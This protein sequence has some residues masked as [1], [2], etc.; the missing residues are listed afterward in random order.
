MKLPLTL[1]ALLLTSL[2]AVRA[3]E[4]LTV[5]PPT[6]DGVAPTALLEA[7]LKK[8]AFAALDRRDA[9]YEKIKTPEDVAAWQKRER[10]AFLT[11][12]GGLPERTPLNARV[13]GQRDCGEYR[14]EKVLFESQPGF[15]V[16]GLLY[17]PKGGGPH[18]AVLMPCGHTTIAKAGELYQRASISLARAGLAVFCYD[19]IGQGERRQYRK[20]DG[21]AEFA[22]STLEHQLMGIA[23][24]PLGT[25]LARVMIWDGMRALDYLQSRPE[26]RKDKLGCTGVSGGGT[27][28]SYLVALDD[29][30][31]AAAPACYLTGFRRLLETIG[32]QDFE[33]NQFGQIAAGLDHA[34]YVIQAAP[35]PVLIMAATRDFFDI[36][37]AWNVFRQAKRCYGRLGL[38]EHVG[39]IE[40][41]TKHDLAIDMREASARWFRRWLLG[42]DDAWKEPADLH[43]LPEAEVL[44][45][46][47]GD[48]LRQ[49]GARSFF[50]LNAATAASLVA[51]R[52]RF[53]K[54]SPPAAR[55]AKVRELAGIRPLAEIPALTATKGETM[56]RGKVRIEKLILRNAEGTVLPA[57]VFRPAEVAADRKLVLYVSGAGKE[58]D[59]GAGGRLEKAA[60]DGSTV[61]AV[62]I[63]GLGEMREKK[64]DAGF[65]ALG[66]P[67]WKEASI[68]SLLG[69]PL[70]GLRAEDILACARFGSEQFKA[71]SRILL[72]AS[73]EAGVPAL[74]AA[75]LEPKLIDARI[76][77]TLLSWDNVARSHYSKNQQVNTVH[78]ALHFY[79]LPN[80]AAASGAVIIEPVD[81]VGAVVQKTVSL[82]PL[83]PAQPE[84]FAHAR[85]TEAWAAYA[86]LLT[87]G[88]GQTLALLDDGCTM[89]RPEWQAV[90]DGVPKVRVTFDAVDGD[91]DPKHEGKG[92][93]GSTIGIPS[94]VNYAGKR[95]VAYNDQV[96]VVRSL[97]CCHCKLAD[98]A[99][100]ARALQWVIDHHAEHRITTVNLSPVDDLAHAEPVPTEIDPK[101]AELRGL[102]IWV[103]A[104]AGNHNFTKGISWPASQPNCFAIGAVK[105]G[106]DVVHLDRHEKVEL[107][108]PASATSSS[109]A[110]ICGAAMILREAIEKNGYDWKTDGP[111]IAEAMMAIFKN[112]GATVNDPGPQRS[113]RRLDLMAALEHV[114]KK[115]ANK[116]QN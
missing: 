69:R 8:L 104:P 68:A 12:I 26:I 90:I 31:A 56:E 61:L 43:P 44:C 51:E 97:E 81:A 107:L 39:L 87:F 28:T 17:L 70:V 113:Y 21:T 74:H 112:T 103:S 105:P 40:A 42:R 82:S 10:A 48:V 102:G 20:P 57:L 24:T 109:N 95:G 96:A 7:Q 55:L 59:A 15:L 16:S 13:T 77:R 91:N 47:E 75:A 58:A 110:I 23:G 25:G 71:G 93:H 63:R 14:M 65:N 6:I 3:A 36:Q 100:L 76:E 9:E 99:S 72:E 86:D 79:D 60:L 94:S 101:L 115:P 98:S 53:W 33:Q 78:G 92:Y 32:P 80:L 85:I 64:A 2:C 19:P 35:R 11:A 62:D 5:L 38:P 106:Q 34:D 46:P 37:G 45:T 73:G 54:E 111:N 66:A 89:S 29:R 67:N 18:A 1:A 114:M 83:A 50:D 88:R 49:P 84:G 27:Q 30:I 52:E 108:V 41:D 116:S 22:S 4:D